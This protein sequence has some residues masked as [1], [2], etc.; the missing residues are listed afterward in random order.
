M[1]WN[2]LIRNK[3]SLFV[4]TDSRQVTPARSTIFVAL[5]GEH[6][7]GNDFV[8]QA[9]EQGAEWVL[10]DNQTIYD[11][12]PQGLQA[13]IIFSPSPCGERGERF[14]EAWLCSNPWRARGVSRC[15][16]R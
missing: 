5:K 10:M 2:F 1:D 7:D 13:R 9:L 14:R 8:E 6:F 16:Y 11:R 3:E 12:L 15:R 4:T